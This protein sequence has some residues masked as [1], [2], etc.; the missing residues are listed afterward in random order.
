MNYT[1]KFSLILILATLLLDQIGVANAS[2]KVDINALQQ[3]V[4]TLKQG[5]ADLAKELAEVKKL[6]QQGAKA[7]PAQPAFKPADLLVG[8]SATLGNNSAPVTLFEFSDYQC[9]FCK[10]HATQVMPELVKQYVESGKLRIVHREFPLDGL[11]PRATAASQAAL[12]AGAQGKYHEMHDLLFSDQRAVADDNLQ[13]YANSL[14]LDADAYAN[15]I[16]D[17]ATAQT[18]KDSLNEGQSLGISGTPSFVIG[19]TDGTDF[20]KVHVTKYIRGAQPL[21]A[22]QGAIEELLKEANP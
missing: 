1:I 22:F 13:A 4:E 21:T 20:N 2:S 6:V 3:E 10:R 12:C 5:Q 8:T 14:N 15:C 16:T 18:I 17:E 11:H 19:L 9:P 7:A